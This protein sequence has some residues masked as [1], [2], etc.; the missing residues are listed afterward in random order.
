MAMRRGLWTVNSLSVEVKIDRRTLAKRLEGLPT[1]GKVKGFPAW[2]LADVLAHLHAGGKDE[3]ERLSY[4]VEKARFAKEQ[5]DKLELENAKTRGELLPADEVARAD[6]AIYTA[7]R[8]GFLA[9]PDAVADQLCEIAAA[10]G[11]ASVATFLRERVE[12]LL[13]DAAE[14]EIELIDEDQGERIAQNGRCKAA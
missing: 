8:D 9:L 11:P 5:A 14:A 4:E 6:E 2:Y 1:T 3:G 10:E 13:V 7:I 12:A